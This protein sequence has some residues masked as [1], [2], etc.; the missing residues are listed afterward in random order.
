[1]GDDH[2]TSHDD[3]T[4][5]ASNSAKVAYLEK[6]VQQLEEEFRVAAAAA[7]AVHKEDLIPPPSSFD[8]YTRIPLIPDLSF[9]RL[10]L[11][12]DTALPLGSFAFSSGLESYLTHRKQ[13]G[14]ARPPPAIDTLQRF[15]SLSL[16]SL[17]STTV[18]FI[19]AAYSIP[20]EHH[21]GTGTGT[22]GISSTPSPPLPSPSPSPSPSSSSSSSSSQPSP[23]AVAAATAAATAAIFHLNDTFD[24]TTTCPVLRRASTTQGKALLSVWDKCLRPSS[25]TTTYQSSLNATLGALI[26]SFKLSPA[27][28]P[29]HLPISWSLVC[30]A[31]GL[32]LEHTTFVFLLNHTKALLSAAVRLN[33]IGPYVAQ[34]TLAAPETLDMVRKAQEVGGK[35]TIEEAGQTV[36][37][38]DLYQG[39]H[40]L[41]YSR[42]FNS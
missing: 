29:P 12:S 25:S 41:L 19:T 2:S 9:H 28:C 30:L 11:L 8:Y 32:A 35:L 22:T 24:A 14:P 27:D 38:L 10:L 1:M 34:K 3:E 18:P 5:S 17:A 26:S 7:A 33:L 39:R 36:P 31:S 13:S 15:L 16:T 6:R 21:L 4:N 23:D 42:V 37:T 40:E 20:L